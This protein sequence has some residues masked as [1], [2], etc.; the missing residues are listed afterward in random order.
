[1]A[2]GV[3]GGLAG[4]AAQEAG[5]QDVVRAQMQ[6]VQWITDQGLQGATQSDL[7]EGYCDVLLVLGVPLRRVH[8]TH[9]ALHP[10]YGGIG[11]TWYRGE[12]IAQ[13]HYQHAQN[14]P[15][16]WRDSPLYAMLASAE[17]ELRVDLRGAAFHSP[18]PMLHDLR[19]A[20]VTDYFATGL[21]FEQGQLGVPLDPHN[22][23]EGMLISWCSDSP[24][25]FLDRDIALLRGTLPALGLALKSISTR[26]SGRDLLQVYL[27]QDAGDR[28]LRGEI[29]RGS[30]QELN[31]VVAY[32][33]LGGFTELTER[34][35]GPQL[36]EMLNAYF[37]VVVD[38]V[39]AHGGNVLK[40]MGDG[41]LV[42]FD[43][44][45][46]TASARAALDMAVVLTGA[47]DRLNRDRRARGLPVTSH[48]LA[49]HAG[50]IL[51]GNIGAENRLDFT[52]IGPA[53]NLTARLSGMHTALGQEVI[54]SQSVQ[55][56]AAP[57]D[58]D[59]VSLGRYMLRGVSKPLELFTIYHGTE[60]SRAF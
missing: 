25:G 41:A 35:P 13:E 27:G 8:A 10:V 45:T 50:D 31:A 40:F 55:R 47:L 28:V 6:V 17:K 4:V 46:R 15:E 1:M 2:G 43:M 3:S 26:Q 52:V 30:L 59:L 20:G 29:Q 58:H 22:T 60:G 42:M 16:R 7:I 24:Q 5:A 48:T 11:L 36:I 18:H 19:A 34:T 38:L 57:V 49:I 44:P 12:G 33:D 21:L 32:F 51:Y 37:G 54:V 9:R 14:A 56:A 53:V 23:P 39:H